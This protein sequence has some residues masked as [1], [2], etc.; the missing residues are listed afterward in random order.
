MAALDIKK[1][2]CVIKMDVLFQLWFTILISFNISLYL[3]K[4]TVET[5]PC[6]IS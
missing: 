6:L 4:I 2:K 5:I 1:T 3:K